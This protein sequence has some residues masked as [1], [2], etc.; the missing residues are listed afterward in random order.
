MKER[1]RAILSFTASTRQARYQA[2][3]IVQGLCS[4]CGQEP[5][6]I[7][8]IRMGEKCLLKYRLTY[9]AKR[10]CKPWTKGNQG[11]PPLPL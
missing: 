10:N 2:R 8:S 5:L 11:R 4:Q 6:A 9:R 1:A 3:K 7:G